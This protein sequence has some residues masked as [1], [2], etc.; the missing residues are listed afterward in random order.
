MTQPKYN[1]GDKVWFEGSYSEWLGTVIAM[2]KVWFGYK[3][4][5]QPDELPNNYYVKESKIISKV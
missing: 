5:L 1:I 2:K 4:L 3:Y